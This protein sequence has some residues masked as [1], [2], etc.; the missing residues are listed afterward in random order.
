MRAIQHT[1]SLLSAGGALLSGL[2]LVSMVAHTIL[3]MV[4][5]A[6]FS[7]STFVLDEF[8]GYQ[9]AALTMLGLG[10]ALH[11]G[12]LIRVSLLDRIL[13]GALRRALELVSVAAVLALCVYLL[14][15]YGLAIETAWIRGTRSN[16][17]A[18]TPLW[19]PMAVFAAGLVI[20]MIQLAAYGLR[21]LTG[22]TIRPTAPADG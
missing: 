21:V 14:R 16:T 12:G 8:V 11:T 19:I 3:E 10:H 15:Y 13:P 2:L 1:A 6:A 18:A 9:V 20:F 5:R 7:T 17:V 22:D 4:L